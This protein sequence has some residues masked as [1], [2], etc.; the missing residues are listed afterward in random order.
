MNNDIQRWGAYSSGSTKYE[1]EVSPRLNGG[2]IAHCAMP[3]ISAFSATSGA[4]AAHRL[5]GDLMA[6]GYDIVDL[7]PDG[8]PTRRELQNLLKS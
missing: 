6:M 7:C 8:T 2:W 4:H 5:C 1:I 3:R